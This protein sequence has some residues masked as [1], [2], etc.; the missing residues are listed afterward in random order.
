[1]A[2]GTVLAAS[3]IA[4]SG[5]A[6]AALGCLKQEG[7]GLTSVGQS[8][9]RGCNDLSGTG[10]ASLTA[11]E[12]TQKEYRVVA[13]LKKA[14][15]F[16]ARMQLLTAGGNNLGCETV[17]QNPSNASFTDNDNCE[18]PNATPATVFKFVAGDGQGA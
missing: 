16:S 9:Q 8:K 17:D 3:I 5:L 14:D 15:A 4:Q 7:L 1:M 18:F 10:S 13:N 6:A 11:I 12:S 2:V